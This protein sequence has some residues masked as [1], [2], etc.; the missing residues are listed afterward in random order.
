LGGGR[1]RERIIRSQFTVKGRRSPAAKL[2][3]SHERLFIS[4]ERLFISHERHP[5]A[6]AV[7]G[8]RLPPP[9]HLRLPFIRSDVL[10]ARVQDAG[11][12][13]EEEGLLTAYNK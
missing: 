10:G 1:E 5:A 7:R 12:D 13:E 11:G 3:I 4:H 6:V 9:P 2:F 8:D